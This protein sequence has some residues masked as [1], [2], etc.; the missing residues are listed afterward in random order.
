M[1]WRAGAGFLWCFD[2]FCA[3]STSLVCQGELGVYFYCV[4]APFPHLLP[5]LHT[6]VGQRWIGNHFF[7]IIPASFTSLAC[8]SEPEVGHH[9]VLRLVSCIFLLY[10]FASFSW[11]LH[12][13]YCSLGSI[14]KSQRRTSYAPNICLFF[15]ASHILCNPHSLHP[16]QRSE[17]SRLRG[18]F[19]A[20]RT[21]RSLRE[22]SKKCCSILPSLSFFFCLVWF[23]LIFL[24]VGYPKGS[25]RE[26]HLRGWI[27]GSG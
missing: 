2:T 25:W 14:G 19:T 26:Q 1:Q 11:N 13:R 24:Q 12:R 10:I 23:N 16:G 18:S 6:K 9:S 27:P 8:S 7:D 4:S 15:Y 5:P 17:F 22:C 20:T 3:S 21:C